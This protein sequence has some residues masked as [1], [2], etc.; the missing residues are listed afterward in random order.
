MADPVPRKKWKDGSHSLP[1]GGGHHWRCW[2]GSVIHVG[3]FLIHGVVRQVDELI[4]E[5]RTLGSHIILRAHA[6]Q[7][8]PMNQNFQI[9]DV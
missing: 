5:I 8:L 9:H 6:H 3:V 2:R 4:R 1:L 7:S